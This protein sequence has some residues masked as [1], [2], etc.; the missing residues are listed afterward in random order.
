[1]NGVGSFEWTDC[2]SN[3]H[4]QDR[5]FPRFAVV[6][7]L[8]E[9][10]YCR[11]GVLELLSG[12]SLQD[13]EGHMAKGR[14]VRVA[15]LQF[16]HRRG[17]HKHADYTRGECSLIES[18]NTFPGFHLYS[19]ETGNGGAMQQAIDRYG[20]VAAILTFEPNS[21]VLRKKIKAG[22]DVYECKNQKK[23]RGLLTTFHVL[24]VGFNFLKRFWKIKHTYG[25]VL[26]GD[27]NG[28][29][30]IAMYADEGA[31]NDCGIADSGIFLNGVK[32]PN[33]FR[34]QM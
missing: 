2:V 9:F 23:K 32:I 27:K 20:I 8:L 21:L 3:A 13:C 11:E 12:E 33:P 10:V 29:M 22:V 25:N 30:H 6:L 26:G 5:I 19:I 28:Y 34:G 14:D 17:I 31:R 7:G 4:Q 18:L 15:A 24:V 1:M 16:V